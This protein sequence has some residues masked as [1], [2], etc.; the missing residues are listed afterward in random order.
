M[1]KTDI[2]N[3]L[4]IKLNEFYENK[5]I[6]NLN[7]NLNNLSQDENNKLHLII[8][9]LQKLKKTN[10]NKYKILFKKP[11]WAV[12]RINYCKVFS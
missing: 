4:Y 1:Q 11:D 7:K 2:N 6:Y 10:L 8:E 9:S 3:N 12:F 5:T